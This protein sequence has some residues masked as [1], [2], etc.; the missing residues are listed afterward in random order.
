MGKRLIVLALILI[1]PRQALQPANFTHNEIEPDQLIVWRVTNGE[2][3]TWRHWSSPTPRCDHFSMGG[4]V[5]NLHAMLKA[6]KGL[7][8]RLWLLSTAPEHLSSIRSFARLAPLCLAHQI[9]DDEAQRLPS[10]LSSCSKNGKT[11][12]VETHSLPKPENKYSRGFS[13]RVFLIPSAGVLILGDAHTREI[14][15]LPREFRET[16]LKYV[17][18]AQHGRAAG[19]PDIFFQHRGSASRPTAVVSDLAQGSQKIPARRYTVKSRLDLRTQRL[20]RTKMWPVLETSKWG[21]LQLE[22]PALKTR[23]QHSQ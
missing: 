22:L 6:C 20:F 11:T 8:N 15:K 4:R 7:E 5:T 13:R 3:I 14:E 17:V 12:G 16:S 21:H 19:R 23:L 1:L 10:R 18:L 9:A 2:W